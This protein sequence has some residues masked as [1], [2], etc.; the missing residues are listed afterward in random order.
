MKMR[1][2][3]CLAVVVLQLFASAQSQSSYPSKPITFVVPYAAGGLPDTV[4]RVIAQKLGERLGGSVVVDNKP[5]GNGIVAYQTLMTAPNDGHTFVVSDGSWLSI[6]PLLNKAAT[7]SIDKDLQPVALIA[8]SPLFLVSHPKSGINS[9]GD[10]VKKVREKPGIYSYGSSG[11]GSSHHL[12]MEALKADLK[13]NILHVPFRGSASSVP[14]L[15]GGQVDFLFAALPSM[16]GFIKAQQVNLIASNAL[17]RSQ[18]V[19]TV[20]TISEVIPGFDFSVVIGIVGRTGTSAEVIKRISDE[21]GQISKSP[22]VIEKFK[23]AGIDSVGAN[24]QDYR[25]Q[26]QAEIKAMS[27]A[28]KEA[29]LKAE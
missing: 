28:G 26:I 5:G 8:R 9:L 18:S 16:Q 3:Q 19:S 20:P 21:V 12:T 17:K 25:T 14:A 29:D 13:L 1:F 22:D 23:N 27:K 10:F 6:T 4:A 24:S 15:V 7:Y 11:I 2:L